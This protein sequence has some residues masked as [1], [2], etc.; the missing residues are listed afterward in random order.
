MPTRT[1]SPSSRRSSSRTGRSGLSRVSATISRCRP[2]RG[3]SWSPSSCPAACPSTRS[4]APPCRRRSP[5]TAAPTTSWATA[6]STAWPPAARLI[7]GTPP[8]ARCC[9]PIPAW[10]VASARTAR[11]PPT[12]PPSC[13]A[14]S[15][16]SATTPPPAA[17]SASSSS[18]TAT[19]GSGTCGAPTE[20]S[21][22]ASSAT[23][24]TRNAS[25]GRC[26]S[27]GAGWFS[28]TSANSKR[29]ST[30]ASCGC[31]T[32]TVATW[33]PARPRP[34]SSRCSGWTRSAATAGWPRSSPTISGRPKS[35]N[36]PTPS[37][38][39]PRRSGSPTATAARCRSK[40]TGGWT[41]GTS[42][43]PTR[44]GTAG[45][46]SASRLTTPTSSSRSRRWAL[47]RSATPATAGI[48]SSRPA[49]P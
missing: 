1:A 8:T 48:F 40:L 47:A 44:W 25:S 45:R 17:T 6:T 34:A 19:S 9:G 14:S 10:A 24:A 27:T 41:S 11:R 12:T 23:I 20:C 37:A 35:G 16:S 3:G 46:A 2:A 31:A 13:C 26:R 33:S 22:G 49:P 32:T 29:P 36:G 42:C 21:P 15:A 28:T 7:P 5:A 18:S 43:P 4:N 30:A 39:S 38:G